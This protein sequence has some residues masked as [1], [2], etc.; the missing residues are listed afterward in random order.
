M[1]E[2]PFESTPGHSSM[3]PSHPEAPR[4]PEPS[5]VRNI[6][7]W[8]MV[9]PSGHNLDVCPAH[10]EGLYS[11]SFLT[12]GCRDP[13]CVPKVLFNILTLSTSQFDFGATRSLKK[14]LS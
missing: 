3:R 2:A 8:H 6:A 10:T 12:E 5:A 11:A 1:K 13:N 4:L 9:V 14:S 7:S